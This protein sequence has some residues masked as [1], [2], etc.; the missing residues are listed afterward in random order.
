MNALNIEIFSDL[1]CP[2]CYIGRHRLEAALKILEANESPNIVW[3]P[4]EL[5]PD[6]QRMPKENGC[7]SAVSRFQ[8]RPKAIANKPP[9]SGMGSCRSV[10]TP[11]NARHCCLVYATGRE[12]RM[13]I[14]TS[15]FAL[16]FQSGPDATLETPIRARSRSSGSRSGRMSPLS[17]AR[18]TNAFIAPLI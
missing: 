1:I 4:F 8:E 18:S 2:W 5:N 7:R 9:L 13:R 10:S 16:C 6:L 14:S 11:I 3:R 12:P 15:L 17:I